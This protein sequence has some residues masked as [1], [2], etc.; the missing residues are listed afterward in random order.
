LSC[1]GRKS[2][3]CPE[4]GEASVVAVEAEEEEE[5]EEEEEMLL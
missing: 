2:L 5:E 1:R 3:S 4:V